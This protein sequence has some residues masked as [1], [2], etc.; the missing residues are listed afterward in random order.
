MVGTC[1]GHVAVLCPVCLVFWALRHAQPSACI[2]LQG[3]AKPP[4]PSYAIPMPAY[5]IPMPD[6]MPRFGPAP[7]NKRLM[8]LPWYIYIE[9]YCSTIRA[10]TKALWENLFGLMS[11]SHR[12]FSALGTTY[13]L[14][15]IL[16][17]PSAKSGPKCT[18]CLGE[19]IISEGQ[20]NK[21]KH[22]RFNCFLKFPHKLA[23]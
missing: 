19:G 11:L 5:A 18:Q 22:H 6:A 4:T 2:V 1:D 17:P 7:K 23:G 9:P 13:L 16:S 21:S 20:N 14:L 10:T 8:T 3:F 12:N 15:V